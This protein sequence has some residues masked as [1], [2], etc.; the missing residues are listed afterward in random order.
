[1]GSIPDSYFEHP[2]FEFQYGDRPL[3]GF[4]LSFSLSRKKKKG[5]FKKATPLPPAQFQIRPSQS[6]KPNFAV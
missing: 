1:M 3:T 6:C 2:A 5:N 4:W